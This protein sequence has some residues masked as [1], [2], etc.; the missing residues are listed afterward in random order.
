MK[1]YVEAK[2]GKKIE[3]AEKLRKF[4]R[5]DRKVLRF[6]GEWDDTASVYGDRNAYILQYFLGNDTVDVREVRVH[7]SGKEPFAYL[8]ARQRL[9]KDYATA[10]ASSGPEENPDLYYTADDFIVGNFINV[11]GRPVLL[12]SCDAFTRSFY[13][14]VLGVEQPLPIPPPA[15]EDKTVVHAIPPP[16]GYGE[17]A[18]SLG[19]FYKLVP[20]PPK[21]DYNKLVELDGQMYRFICRFA[22]P[23]PEDEMRRFVIQ[24]FPADDSIAIFEPAIRNSGIMGGKFLSRFKHKK[25]DGTLYTAAD[26]T[27]GGEVEVHGHVFLIEDADGFTRTQVGLPVE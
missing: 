11:L 1:R 13:S 19:S 9:P 17:D 27:L 20:Q 25:P 18:D 24:L 16:T 7:N 5:N 14:D 12:R 8:L 15:A 4:L 26:F 10:K 3:S 21:K 23:V 6:E 2:L 22:R